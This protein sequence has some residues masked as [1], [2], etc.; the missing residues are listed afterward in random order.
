M[1]ICFDIGNS[2]INIGYCKGA[3]LI[4][5]R[6]D[7][8]PVFHQ[9]VYYSLMSD[10]IALNNIEKDNVSCIICS[11]V[12]TH[13]DVFEAVARTFAGR[14]GTVDV[15]GIR[16]NTGLDFERLTAPEE[17]GADRIA[18]SA[19]AYD[20]FGGPVL[21]VDFGTATTVTAVDAG[22]RLL[23]GSIMP[24][25]GLMNSALE[26]GTSKLT[27]VPLIGPAAA[28]GTDTA[29]CICSGLFFGTAGAVERI[30]AGIEQ[31]T[32]ASFRMVIT[33]GYGG[34]MKNYIKRQYDIK[35]DL[36]FEGLRTLYD[37]NRK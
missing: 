21:V 11:V 26:K 3:G 33:G 23:G 29:Q 4:V 16:M 31:E 18:T 5:Q 2:S 20:I 30:A 34:M 9:D 22:G 17:L 28:L 8:H 7:T 6:I 19:G 24:G 27:E 1:L 32:G 37:K 15:V 36:I 25:L 10:F 35:P 14:G 13:T 12:D